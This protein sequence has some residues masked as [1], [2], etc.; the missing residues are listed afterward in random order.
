MWS[1]AGLGGVVGV[2]QTSST[3]TALVAENGGAATAAVRIIT[4]IL[5][6]IVFSSLLMFGL[7]LEDVPNTTLRNTKGTC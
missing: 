1:A 2:V 5:N 7:R 4:Q 6:L 3:G